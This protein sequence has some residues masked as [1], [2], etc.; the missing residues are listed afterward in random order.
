MTVDPNCILEDDVRLSRSTYEALAVQP[1]NRIERGALIVCIDSVTSN[2][3]VSNA[4]RI[5]KSVG[6]GFSKFT[7]FS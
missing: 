1:C 4:L 6:C 5:A 3:D 7:N 2:S